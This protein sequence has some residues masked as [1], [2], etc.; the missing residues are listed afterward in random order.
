MVA[1]ILLIQPATPI[2]NKIW[3]DVLVILP[4]ILR[5]SRYVNISRELLQYLPNGFIRVNWGK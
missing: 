2:A 5:R 3:S 4:T 1:I